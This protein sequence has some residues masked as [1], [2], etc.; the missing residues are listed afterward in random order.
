MSFPIAIQVYS[1]R[2]EAEA[3]LRDTLTKLKEFGYDGVE[4]AG[5]Y[6]HSGEEVKAMCDEIGI[7]P[8]SGHIGLADIEAGMDELIATY[9]AVGVKYLGLAWL[10]E[11]NRPGGENWPTVCETL[12]EFG[13]KAKEAGITFLYHN[14]DFEF[15]KVDDKYVL[16][17]IYDS[18]SA[19]YLQSELDTCWVNV[20]GE[21]PAN[22][23]RKFAGRA[24][25]VH[26]K[27]FVG[28]KSDN[29]YAL[30]GT[31]SAKEEKQA[32]FELRPLG[33]GIQD[34]PA[35]IDAAKFAGSEWLIAELDT[36]PAGTTPLECAKKSREYLKSIGY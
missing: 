24:P 6:G 31:D 7:I 23:V 26:L 3:N 34:F 9:K 28:S 22:Y 20:G 18:I 21:N 30:I 2:D 32:T 29:M 16:E 11:E 1:V 33:D 4:F 15:E 12:T 36:A 13:K 14:H 27:D 17:H 35:I 25:V 5:L 10:A 19:D 8:V